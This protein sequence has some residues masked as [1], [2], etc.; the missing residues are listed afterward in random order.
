[1]S[2][3]HCRARCD[4][5]RPLLARGAAGLCIVLFAPAVWAQP[6]MVITKTE[7]NQG[8]AALAAKRPIVLADASEL[9]P[10]AKG[11]PFEK[12]NRSFFKGQDAIDRKLFRPVALGYKHFV[13]AFLRSAIRNLLH[14][15]S[16]PVVFLNDVLQ[17]KPKAA[18]KTLER[19]A[20]NTT[21]G[22]GGMID[23]AKKAHLPY[24]KNG[25]ANTL[26]RY[27]VGPG[28][29]LYLPL[30]GPTT[31]RD[32]FGG[33]V[34]GVIPPTAIGFP[35]N[36]LDYRLS[37]AVTGT[38]DLRAESDGEVKV[39][40]DGAADPYA[41]LRSVYLQNR[42]AE[43]DQLRGK[44]P[45]TEELLDPLADPAAAQPTTANPT[46]PSP[47]LNPSTPPISDD[48]EPT[49]EPSAE[50]AAPSP[51]PAPDNPQLLRPNW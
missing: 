3:L 35:Y 38:L 16:L 51:M 42:A 17:L 33:G 10:R 15:L 26:G 19:F 18:G 6:P 12:S 43:I 25:F 27:G 49:A 20:I 48:P 46:A 36:R 21:V 40:L 7:Q 1:V 23:V 31:V 30:I 45:A 9:H 29:Y 50:R 22:I 44:K 34:D 8:E 28:P 24:R 41:T 14:E 37:T 2:P 39:L 11:D 4:H 13:P 5:Y 32:L 47:L